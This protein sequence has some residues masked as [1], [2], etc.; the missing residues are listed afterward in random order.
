MSNFIPMI[1]G[2]IIQIAG[3]SLLVYLYYKEKIHILY[4]N[5]LT[6]I[7]GVFLIFF[8]LFRIILIYEECFETNIPPRK[9]ISENI[10]IPNSIVAEDTFVIMKAG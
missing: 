9:E 4:K 7:L 2:H 1:I 8:G 3:G 10:S 6:F 5:K